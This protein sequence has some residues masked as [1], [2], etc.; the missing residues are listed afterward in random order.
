M[1]GGQDELVF[2]GG[3]FVIDS[4]GRLIS[5]ADR[6]RE[7]LLIT[8]IEISPKPKPQTFWNAICPSLN[9]SDSQGNGR[10]YIE[11]R[12]AQE[13]G[14]VE[15]I[16]QALTLGVG[17]YVRKN[18]FETVVIGLSG[19]IDSALTAAV[20]VEALGA[21]RVVGV[22]MPSLYTSNETF[23]DAGTLAANLGIELMTVPIEDIL[24]SFLKV[25][26]GRSGPAPWDSRRRTFRLG[27]GAQS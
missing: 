16:F 7:D 25:L 18:G 20:A 21:N 10:N 6:F 3:S 8:D 2:D 26:R 27:S 19:G 13:L 4:A 1:I 11:P 24:N 14:E 22:T 15:E 23:S 12:I 17:D 5:S 9:L